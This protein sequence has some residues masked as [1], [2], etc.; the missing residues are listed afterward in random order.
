M[1]TGEAT[2]SRR[3]RLRSRE[4]RLKLPNLGKINLVLPLDSLGNV[5]PRY[6]EVSDPGFDRA[7]INPFV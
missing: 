3:Q 7:S 4:G 6:N 5:V 1:S 2:F